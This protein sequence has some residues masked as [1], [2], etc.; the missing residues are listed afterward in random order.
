MLLRAI[1]TLDSFRIM[2]VTRLLKAAFTN[3]LRLFIF[4]KKILE[5]TVKICLGNAE[6]RQHPFE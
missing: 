3:I 4:Q 1:L 5:M 2:F 6:F